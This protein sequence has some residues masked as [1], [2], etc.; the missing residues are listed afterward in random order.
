MWGVVPVKEREF[1]NPL[2]NLNDM[3]QDHLMFG[4][5]TCHSL[6]LIDGKL[7]GDPLDVKV[8]DALQT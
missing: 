1:S 5:A 7:I 2:K 6:T 8:I 3:E 4:M